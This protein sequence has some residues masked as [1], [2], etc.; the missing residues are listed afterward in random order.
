MPP[1][2]PAG[3]FIIQ[4]N[5]ALFVATSSFATEKRTSCKITVCFCSA[6]LNLRIGDSCVILALLCRNKKNPSFHIFFL[7]HMPSVNP[8]GL[9][10][11][12]KPTC[13]N[14]LSTSMCNVETGSWKCVCGGGVLFLIFSLQWQCSLSGDDAFPSN[15]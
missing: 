5:H 10:D 11:T 14:C 6:T 9:G 13:Y 2:P 8:I 3:L 7:L 4:L 12:Y 15:G 1:P